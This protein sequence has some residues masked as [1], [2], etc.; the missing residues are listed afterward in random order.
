MSND[1]VNVEK[2]EITPLPIK[3]ES[4]IGDGVYT[5]YDGMVWYGIR[6]N[7]NH[8]KYPTDTVYLEPDVLKQ[9]VEY[10]K[11]KGIL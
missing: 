10:A 9:L 1:K 11:T 5:M 6:L 3:D 4:Y 8:H 2:I 7:V